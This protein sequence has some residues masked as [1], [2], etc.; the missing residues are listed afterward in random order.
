MHSPEKYAD[1]MFQFKEIQSGY[2][3]TL[4]EHGMRENKLALVYDEVR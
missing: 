1:L 3:R 4:L 2:A